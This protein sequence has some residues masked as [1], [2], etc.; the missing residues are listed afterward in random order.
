MNIFVLIAVS[1]VER[2]AIWPYVHWVT[3]TFIPTY[4]RSWAHWKCE[5][6]SGAKTQQLLYD[7]HWMSIIFNYSHILVKINLKR[8]IFTVNEGCYQANIH[9]MFG[10]STTLP[11]PCA[12]VVLHHRTSQT[13]IPVSTASGR[14]CLRSCSRCHLRILR[15][16]DTDHAASPRS[17]PQ[18]GTHFQQPFVTCHHHPASVATWK[19]NYLAGPMA[20]TST[21]VIATFY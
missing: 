11:G 21:F 19:L 14:S 7:F 17:A 12:F 6:Q 13:C 18:P 20:W 2:L 4:F 8:K 16:H 10:S 15:C 9:P 5:V 1:D 3:G